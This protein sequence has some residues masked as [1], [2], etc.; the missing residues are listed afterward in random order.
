M[1]Y[2]ASVSQITVNKS[3][4]SVTLSGERQRQQSG[5]DSEVQAGQHQPRRHYERR[6]GKF[7]RTIPAIPEEADL[8]SVT[9]R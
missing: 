4:R 1:T 2:T 6:M 9:A 3:E 8:S 7:Q 5:D